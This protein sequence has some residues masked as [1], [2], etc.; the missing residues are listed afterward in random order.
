MGDDI[1]TATGSLLERIRKEIIACGGLITFARFM[2]LALYHP[3]LGYYMRERRRPGRGGDFITAPEASPYFGHTLARQLAE[4][5]ERLDRPSQWTIREYGSGIGGLA[6]DIMAGLDAESSQAFDALTCQLVEINPAMRQESL[7]SM[8]EAGLAGKVEVTAP[9]ALPPIT[10]VLLA[11]EVADALPVHRLVRTGSGWSEAWVAI[12]G[13]GFAW[14]HAGVSREAEPALDYLRREGIDPTPGSA[15][16]ISPA[17][18][19]WM[20]EIACGLGRG[21]LLVLDYGYEASELYRVHR[22]QGTIRGYHGH[23]VTDDPFVRVGEQDLTAHVDFT[24]LR[25][26]GEASGL[27]FAGFTTQ[28]AFLSSLGLGDALL[29]LQREPE[30]S[31]QEYLATQAVV[32]RLIDPGGLG[33]FGVLMMARDAPVDPPLRGLRDRPPGF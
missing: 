23:T 4:F 7:R 26:T 13:E 1:T 8:A 31:L 24:A 6:Y 5:W 20:R 19:E 32:L 21:Y 30:T 27:T 22:L 11:N 3:D 29:A 2:E 15:I 33:R 10:G 16:D 18:M 12:E 14:I 17:S 25:R 9:G 28:G